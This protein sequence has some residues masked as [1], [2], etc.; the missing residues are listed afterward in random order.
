ME[1]LLLWADDLD[2]AVGAIRHLWP[3]VVD[4]FTAALL[5]ATT[6]FA[7]VMVPRST[8]IGVAVLL[9]AVLLEALRQRRQRRIEAK[10]EPVP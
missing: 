2:D 7:L 4:F 3:Q 8:L 6:G 1:F 9:S 10:I 5:F